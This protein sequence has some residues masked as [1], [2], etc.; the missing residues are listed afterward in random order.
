MTKI[1][2]P[3]Q[4]LLPLVLKDAMI[5]RKVHDLSYKSHAGDLKRMRG[6]LLKNVVM[7]QLL[8]TSLFPEIFLN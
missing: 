4:F 3:Y 7:V 5:R 1:D 2:T 8:G 6:K